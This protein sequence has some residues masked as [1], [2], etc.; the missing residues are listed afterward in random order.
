MLGK[1]KL[2]S[3][4]MVCFIAAV[5][6][7]VLAGTALAVTTGSDDMPW[8]KGLD[9]LTTS[10]T[11][12]VAQAIG[13]IAIVAAGAALIFGGDMTGFMRTAVYIVLVLGI[14]MSAANL[15]KAFTGTSATL[16]FLS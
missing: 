5:M 12:P 2:F 4:L 3:R 13:L 9:A 16:P 6:V 10:I 11:G 1:K 15:L 7:M 14:I 8:E